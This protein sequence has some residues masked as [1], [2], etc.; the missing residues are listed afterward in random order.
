M[1]GFVFFFGEGGEG[2]RVGGVGKGEKVEDGK[3]G[4][5]RAWN[6]LETLVRVWGLGCVFFV[7]F[8]KDVSRVFI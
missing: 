7:F 8:P 5:V 1:W 4:W 3:H 6:A 2:L